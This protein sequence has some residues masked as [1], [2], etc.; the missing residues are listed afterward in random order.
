MCIRDSEK[1]DQGQDENHQ[2]C[3]VYNVQDTVFPMYDLFNGHMNHHVSIRIE[4]SCDRRN[5]G[6]HVFIKPV[7]YTHLEGNIAR[8][9]ISGLCHQLV[10]DSVASVD[11]G[12]AVFC[13]KLI[14]D[15]EMSC[16]VKLACR[17]KVVVDQND[18][19]RI[20]QLFNCL[21][22]TSRCV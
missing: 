19:I 1:N 6:Q 10:A 7:S 5:D 17:N 2:R 4:I 20:P 18:L 21:L 8:F 9:Y 12:H 11:V 15:M 16:I 14:A 13:S 22:Y 3:N